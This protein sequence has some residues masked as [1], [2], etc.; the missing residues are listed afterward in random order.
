[1]PSRKFD[2]EM[3]MFYVY[4]WFDFFILL[5]AGCRKQLEQVLSG[6]EYKN[7]E[8]LRLEFCTNNYFEMHELIDSF[9]NGTITPK[10]QDLFLEQRKCSEETLYG[11]FT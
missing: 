1:M 9:L 6:T 11:F 4:L 2:F 10:Y 5:Q 3:L 8:K 7:L